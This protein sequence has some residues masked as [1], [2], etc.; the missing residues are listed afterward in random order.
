V[1]SR[2]LQLTA[3]LV[4]L[5]CLVCPLVEMFDYWDHTIQTGNDTEYVLLVVALCV[6]VACSVARFI[7]KS[8]LAGTFTESVFTSSS[9][10]S[11][12]PTPYGFASLLF[13]ATSPPALPL[14]I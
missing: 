5:V 10:R 4:L 8:P 1:R 7:P 13:D 6:G 12:L 2:A 11:N 9:Q 14:R 3:V